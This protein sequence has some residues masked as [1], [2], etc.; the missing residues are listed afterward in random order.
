MVKQDPKQT[1]EYLLGQL[2]E[3]QKATADEIHIIRTN[4]QQI[5]KDNQKRYDAIEKRLAELEKK[6]VFD[7]G[8][9]AAITTIAA[10]IGAGIAYLF[11]LLL[12]GAILP[13]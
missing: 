12:S 2:V 10:T 9:I 3:G 5:I 13:H 8:F 11:K 7:K 6:N 1:I 4:Q